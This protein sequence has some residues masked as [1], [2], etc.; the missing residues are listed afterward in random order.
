MQTPHPRRAL[1][2]GAGIYGLT[3]A[4][5]L[6]AR[7]WRVEVADP[8]PL[9]HADAASNDISK[10]VRTDYGADAFYTALAEAALRGWGEWNEQWGWPAFERTGFLLLSRRPLVPGSFEHDSWDLALARGQRVERVDARMLRDSFPLWASGPW[11]DG[12]VNLDG[13][14]S[15]S[16]R[17]LVELAQ[18]AAESGVDIQEGRR[19]HAIEHDARGPV[20]R[21]ADGSSTRADGV[22]V[23][24]GSWTPLLLPELADRISAVGQPVFHLRVEDP[25]RFRP[26][27]FRVWAA[28]IAR[29][30][31]YGF[32]ALPDGRLKVAN[33][34][35]GLP[36]APDAPR[37]VR[38]EH[39]THLRA[40]LAEALPEVAQAPIV[41]RRLCVYTETFDNDFLIDRHPDRPGVVVASGGSGHGYKF[42]PLLGPLAADAVEGRDNPWLHRFRWR[43]LG[44]RRTEPARWTGLQEAS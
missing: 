2:L 12:Y 34:G 35:P 42:A 19:A 23:A 18:R 26:P 40:F 6:S 31:W 29:S 27:G 37:V 1:V 4:L 39:E 5:E 16:A 24:A 10:I 20:V 21:W 8:G 11:V 32:P 44:P 33:H 17:V 15:P 30:G 22:V 14:W 7:G 41:Q 3:A 36:L 43:A 25:D 13:G 38:P 9:P 28:D